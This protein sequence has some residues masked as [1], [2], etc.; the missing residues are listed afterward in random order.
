MIVTIDDYRGAV[1]SNVGPGSNELTK[2]EH[3]DCSFT[4]AQA[5]HLKLT[6]QALNSLL[7]HTPLDRH[8]QLQF[9]DV[10]Q[11]APP[12]TYVNG[13]E[14]VYFLVK[15]LPWP[16]KIPVVFAN[17][18]SEV[19]QSRPFTNRYLPRRKYIGPVSSAFAPT[20]TSIR[21]LLPEI[22]AKCNTSLSDFFEKA[23]EQCQSYFHL[24]QMRY[25][26]DSVK[27]FPFMRL[28]AELRLQVY[29]QVYN[30]LV[31]SEAFER[32]QA[33]GCFMMDH[34]LPVHLDIARVSKILHEETT[35]HLFNK[36]A[37]LIEACQESRSGQNSECFT[38]YTAEDYAG[39]I[40]NMSS[41]IRYR[42]T[43]LEI[44]I[45]SGMRGEDRKFV[46]EELGDTPLR[47]I[48]AALPN[49]EFIVISF[50]RAD[51]W[52]Q[53]LNVA[54]KVRFT[55]LISQ[56]RTLD[57]I[58]AQL[59]VRGP[60]V[61]WDLMHFRPFVDRASILRENIMSMWMMRDQIER[62][63]SFELKQ[64]VT[65]TKEEVQRW[66]EIESLILKALSQD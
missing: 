60:R 49:L 4:V 26:Q 21:I 55:H 38:E 22:D 3:D 14:E 63:D 34:P 56:T 2:D 19:A 1:G 54:Q 11:G 44:R 45:V 13:S 39:L 52:R 7:T 15:H 32:V 61:A 23:D 53:R 24:P 6:L 35:E 10:V 9:D 42:F 59:P 51:E 57:W 12:R 65:A 5:G 27:S 48:C 30:R 58:Y 28:P 46:R 29:D 47:Q 20:F 17:A 62:E 37:L 43:I 40:T 41:R 33:K 16:S 66:S 64:S 8:G 31:P 25:L 18:Y 50:D 36:R